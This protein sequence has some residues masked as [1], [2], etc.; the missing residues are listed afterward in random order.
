MDHPDGMQDL[1]PEVDSLV[2]GV[3]PV[4]NSRGASHVAPEAQSAQGPSSSTT[5]SDGAGYTPTGPGRADV[6]RT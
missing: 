6:A 2:R 1:A 4:L 5:R 3:G